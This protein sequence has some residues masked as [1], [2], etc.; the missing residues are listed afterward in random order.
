MLHTPDTD[1]GQSAF[2][3]RKMAMPLTN[4]NVTYPL[5]TMQVS[6]EMV[7]RL[8][9][10][11]VAFSNTH[12]PRLDGSKVN[13]IVNINLSGCSSTAPGKTPAELLAYCVNACPNLQQL[14]A[15]QLGNGRAKPTLALSADGA[16][17][18]LRAAKTHSNVGGSVK[19]SCWTM[20]L[21]TCMRLLIAWK[22]N[23]CTAW[24]WLAYNL[25][26]PACAFHPLSAHC[27]AQHPLSDV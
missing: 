6:V 16:L 18:V 19:T 13:P 21:H 25:D 8:V 26:P 22:W 3:T 12:A 17:Q 4:R 23:F 27:L 15:C 9:T 7:S 14:I 5:E 1:H 11:A 20:V 2:M 10:R 24:A